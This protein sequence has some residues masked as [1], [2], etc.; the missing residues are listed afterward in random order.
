[1]NCQQARPLIEPYADGELDADTIL[2]L[3][4]HLRECTNCTLALRNA[5]TLK[6]AFK[7]N[8]LS[9]SA[10]KDLRRRIK[11]ELHSR[12]APAPQPN[13]WQTPW[14]WNWLTAAIS[15]VATASLVVPLSLSLHNRSQPLEQ[16][17][18]SDHIRSLMGTHTLDVTSTDQHTV[19]PWF[20]GKL[21]FSPPVKDLAPQNFPLIGGR[22]DYVGGRSVASLVFQR[23]KHLI[24][25]FVWPAQER[26][27]KPTLIRPIQGYHLVHWVAADMT[28]WAVSDLNE[29]ELLEFAHAF[30]DI[31]AARP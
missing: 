29:T 11:A 4:K 25:L 10:P 30:A 27:L 16:E 26:D 23:Q 19:K 8:S 20:N 13:F 21:D 17:I 5:T 2:D 12:V 15:S 28:C 14:K 9:F 3:E 6:K 24:N 18:V 31:K 1:M 22:L 7:Q